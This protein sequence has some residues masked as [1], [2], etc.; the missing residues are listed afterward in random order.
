MN[1][2]FQIHRYKNGTYEFSTHF[3][4]YI[5]LDAEVQTWFSNV[6]VLIDYINEIVVMF[7][8]DDRLK[9]MRE[10]IKYLDN[11]S[12]IKSII[13]YEDIAESQIQ[14]V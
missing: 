10:A 6:N 4:R 8:Y 7:E 9:E 13:V 11:Y 1:T 5:A 14:R 3:D 2:I 12:D